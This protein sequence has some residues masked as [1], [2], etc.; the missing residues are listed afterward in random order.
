M[1]EWTHVLGGEEGTIM[2][3]LWSFL[4]S[5]LG[6]AAAAMDETDS[7]KKETRDGKRAFLFYTQ[8]VPLQC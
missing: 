7:L 8:Q 5:S 1:D 4:S 2:H 6:V 3:Y